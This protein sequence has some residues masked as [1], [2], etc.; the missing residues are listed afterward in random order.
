VLNDGEFVQVPADADPEATG[1]VMAA[2][3]LDG[4]SASLRLERD[5]VEDPDCSLFAGR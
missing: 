1:T 4:L 5:G 3:G 2:G